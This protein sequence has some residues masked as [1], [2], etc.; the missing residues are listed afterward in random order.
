MGI[1]FALY[2]GVYSWCTGILSVYLG[3]STS[4]LPEYLCIVYLYILLFVDVFCLYV[5][6]YIY[7]YILLYLGAFFT[8]TDGYISTSIYCCFCSSTCCTSSLISA[9]A[10]LCLGIRSDTSLLNSDILPNAS[11]TLPK[12]CSCLLMFSWN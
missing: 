4:I 3:R 5:G 10:A 8:Y 1:I 9:M 7:L 6:V 11:F 12:V 2:T